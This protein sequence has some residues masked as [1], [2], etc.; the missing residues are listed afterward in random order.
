MKTISPSPGALPLENW[1][2]RKDG[3][4]MTGDKLLDFVNN[5]LFPTLK[6]L[7]VNADT[8]IRKAIVQT[9]FADANN[10]MKDGVLL[11]QV[12]NTIDDL[13]LDDYE[14]SHAFG[15]I[16]ENILKELQSA[17]S[18]GE[19]YTPRAVTDFMAQMIR[20]QVGEQMGRL[21]MWHRRLS[22]Q[23][24]EGAAQAGQDHR[25]RGSLQQFHLWH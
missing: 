3:K 20:P 6:N 19:F 11:R 18:A 14:E 24:A 22:D 9:T 5:T 8:P 23:L 17:G 25:R 15:E 1:A 21:C 12:V 16:Y 10:Y 4:E 13:Q 7:P 2:A